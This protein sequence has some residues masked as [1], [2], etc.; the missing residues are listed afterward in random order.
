MG[1]CLT[2]Q[3]GNFAGEGRDR[4]GNFLIVGQYCVQSGVVTFD[5]HYIGRH[6]IYYRGFAEGRG[7]WGVW[8]VISQR[9]DG[10]SDRGGF[11]IW[12][13][14]MQ[15]QMGELLAV[16]KTDSSRPRLRL[17]TLPHTRMLYTQCPILKKGNAA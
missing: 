3:G 7:I 9:E 2:F 5:K 8:R 4:V 1:L 15:D 14:G 12:P 16:E 13:R 10:F 17:P 11:H 6:S